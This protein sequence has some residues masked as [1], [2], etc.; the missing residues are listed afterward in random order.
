M[1][2]YIR[3]FFFCFFCM[4]QPYLENGSPD[5]LHPTLKLK[6]KKKVQVKGKKKKKRKVKLSL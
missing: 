6:V 5:F 4:L 1:D 2:Y 3:Q